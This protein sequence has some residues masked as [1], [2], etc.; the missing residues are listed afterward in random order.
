MAVA[1]L[2]AVVA[3]P[4]RWPG[5]DTHCSSVLKVEED[6]GHLYP[7]SST[8]LPRGDSASALPVGAK[9]RGIGVCGS[10]R[11]QMSFG[12]VERWNR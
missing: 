8:R 6:A 3:M 10:A 1:V 2:V 11:N 4:A 12:Q 7:R 9:T 5:V